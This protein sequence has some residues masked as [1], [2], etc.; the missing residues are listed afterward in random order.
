MSSAPRPHWTTAEVH[1]ILPVDIDVNA[2]GGLID[3][4]CGTDAQHWRIRLTHSQS[5]SL[6]AKMAHQLIKTTP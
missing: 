5:H 6:I 3:I 4:Y 2:I 1:D